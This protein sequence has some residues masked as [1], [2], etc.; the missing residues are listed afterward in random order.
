MRHGK[1]AALLCIALLFALARIDFAHAA[2]RCSEP[3]TKAGSGDET[4]TGTDGSSCEAISDGGPATASGAGKVPSTATAS[5]DI[6]G[7]GRATATFGGNA[8]AD[9]EDGGTSTAVASKDGNA[10]SDALGDHPGNVPP[11]PDKTKAAA[12]AI[13]NGVAIANADTQ[14]HAVASAVGDGSSATAEAHD[15]ADPSLG[16]RSHRQ[17]SDRRRCVIDGGGW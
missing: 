1:S 5:A 12:V 15:S 4:Q 3:K 9:G 6:F 8:Q 16:R 14:S 17:R 10:V 13:N 2:T 11:G 7:H